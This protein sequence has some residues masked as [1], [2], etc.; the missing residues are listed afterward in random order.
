MS[1]SGVGSASGFNQ[2]ALSGLYSQ[3]KQDFKTLVS[4]V[5]SGDLAGA[6]KALAAWQQDRQSISS[7]KDATSTTA[8]QPASNTSANPVQA[9]FAALIQAIKSGDITGAQNDLTTLQNDMKAQGASGAGHHHHHVRSGEDSDG[10]GKSSVS[11]ASGSSQAAAVKGSDDDADDNGSSGVSTTGTA[12]SS[13][14]SSYAAIA[15]LQTTSTLLSA[16]A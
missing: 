14:V 13:A 7:A 6:Q 1:I 16:S 8:T 9:D 12:N 11:S 3:S 4:D 10:D 2:S 15:N 5:K